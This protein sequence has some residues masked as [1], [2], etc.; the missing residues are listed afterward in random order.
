MRTSTDLSIKNM[1]HELPTAPPD[2]PFG[3][4]DQ[5]L[6]LLSDAL[7]AVDGQWLLRKSNRAGTRLLSADLIAA[8]PTSLWLALPALAPLRTRLEAAMATQQ[9]L[10]LHCALSDDGQWFDVAF[11]PSAAGALLSCRA[12]N[13]N[14]VIDASACDDHRCFAALAE[15]ALDAIFCFDHEHRFTYVNV[16][17]EREIGASRS[18]FV[19]RHYADVEFGFDDCGNDRWRRELSGVFSSGIPSQF[20]IEIQA[21]TGKRWLDVR[22][23][24]ELDDQGQTISAFAIARDITQQKQIDRAMR[25]SEERFLSFFEHASDALVILDADGRCQFVSSAIERNLGYRSADLLDKFAADL[26]HPEDWPATL[27]AIRRAF[28]HPGTTHVCR[29]RV[30]D[31]Q[32][33]WHFCEA[34]GRTGQPGTPMRSLVVMLRDLQTWNEAEVSRRAEEARFRAFVEHAQ[35]I[36]SLASAQATLAYVS[37][38][39]TELLGYSPTELIGRDIGTL[40]HP[41]ERASIMQTFADLCAVPGAKAEVTYRG[42]HKDGSFRVFETRA[43]NLL[44]EADVRGVVL[45][46]RDVTDR[47]TAT[48]ALMSS[49]ERFRALSASSPIGIFQ[50]DNAGCITYAN[51]RLQ[52]IWRMNESQILGVGWRAHVHPDDTARVDV[53]WRAALMAHQEFQLHYR[54]LFADGSTRHVRGRSAPLRD[55]SGTVIGAVGTVWDISESWQMQQALSQSEHSLRLALGAGKMVAWE[56]DL[57]TGLLHQRSGFPGGRFSRSS[58][59]ALRSSRYTEFLATVHPEDRGRLKDACA[60]LQCPGAEMDVEFRIVSPRGRV[61]WLQAMARPQTTLSGV[62]DRVVGISLDVTHRKHMEAELTKRAQQDALTGL[63]NRV[64]FRERLG[65]ALETSSN[66]VAVMF[67]DLDDFKTVNDSLGHTVGDRLLVQVAQRLQQAVTQANPVA[68][69]GGDEFAVLLSRLHDADEANSIAQRIERSLEDAF[70]IDGREIHVGASIGIAKARTEESP[71]E[72]LRNADLAMYRAKAGGKR[73]HETFTPQMHEMAR[74]RQTLRDDL[75]LALEA[76]QFFLRYQPIVELGTR[77]IIGAEALV[78]W[79]HP[80]RGLVSP[81]TFIT[82]AEETGLISG[83]G[84]WVLFEAC[85]CAAQWPR[86]PASPMTLTVNVSA[87]QLHEDG[88]VEHVHGALKASGLPPGAL[89]LEITESTLMQDQMLVLQRLHELKSIGL[90]IAIDDFGTGYS[91]LAYLQQYPIDV[92]KID[93][94]FVD[95]V[96]KGPKDEVVARTVIALANS[97]SLRSVAEGIETPQQ[98]ARLLALGCRHGQGYLFERPMPALDLL[99]VLQDQQASRVRAS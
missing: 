47:A 95:H 13:S 87:T 71:D 1:H 74:E 41:D 50:S 3:Q 44:H 26:V 81:V 39:I 20:V 64:R 24:P 33:V 84:R 67:I 7:F 96:A 35:D 45:N 10:R 76:K 70:R 6:D 88:F 69:L 12:V 72:I 90:Q 78:R 82:L 66:D 56:H 5:L 51:P 89:L 49:E 80:Q 28:H 55:A 53:C 97:L 63:E 27:G 57:T 25:E 42:L 29:L 37:P 32:G 99:H 40:V 11:T 52:E 85:A 98:E 65:S 68:R 18:Y 22:V 16:A 2:E 73:R 38:A 94:S 19:G 31:A 60:S 15:H 8:S 54:L 9:P 36:V 75:Y 34:V 59:E 61:R 92:L 43:W 58:K 91:S 14:V 17:F 83:L 62:T 77:R 79:Q 21:R 93:K 30:I 46:S 48:Q 4:A 86:T 23:V